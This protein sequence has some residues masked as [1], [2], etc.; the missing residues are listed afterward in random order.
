MILHIELLTCWILFIHLVNSHLADDFI[1]SDL[2]I[3]SEAM[4]ATVVRSL[5]LSFSHYESPPSPP[6]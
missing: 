3:F 1:Q 5:A 2:H 6:P 4:I